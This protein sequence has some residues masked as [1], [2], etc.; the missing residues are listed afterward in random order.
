MSSAAP[1]RQKFWT[2]NVMFLLFLMAAGAVFAFKRF[3][4]GFGSVTNLNPSYPMGIWIAFD[5]ACGV[6]LAAG[7]FTTA[8]VVEIFGNH[9]YHALLRPA[10]LTAFIGYLLVGMA[11]AFDLGRWYYIWHTLIYWNGNSVLFEVAWC[12]M[13]YLTVLAVEN[14]PNVIEQYKGNVHLPGKLA[15]FNGPV[16]TLLGAADTVLRR[17]MVFFVIGGVVLSFGHQSSL[18][19]MMLIASYKLHDLWWTPLSPLLFLLS[20][21]SGGIPMVIFE[22]T[23]ATKLFNRK[24]EL[25]LLGGIAKYV[26]WFLGVFLVLR[27]GDLIYRGALPLAFEGTRQGNS[28]LIE[29][30]LFIVPFFMFMQQKTRQSSSRLFLA[31]LSVIL[32]VVL[33]RF[34]VFL[35]GMDMGPGWEYFPS[36]GEFAITFAFVAFGVL[37]YK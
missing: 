37:L 12:V 2:P 21:M 27:I 23:L 7:G 11:V 8:L 19:T 4:F 13:L 24:S 31:A 10:I 16:D 18:G 32:G 9:R 15:T 1:L 5:V 3:F 28:F 25:D 34:N 6:A 14:L 33:Y 36:V 20:A 30:A 26:P 22:G 17:T 29:M 35:I